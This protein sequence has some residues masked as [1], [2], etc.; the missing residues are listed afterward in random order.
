M[1]G[2]PKTLWSPLIYHIL[3]NIGSFQ[4][5]QISICY[6]R[7]LLCSLQKYG[8]TSVP[9]DSVS[10]GVP[11]TEKYDECFVFPMDPSAS[12]KEPNLDC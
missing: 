7:A 6:N 11:A 2:V 3:P 1:G 10:L 12:A 9:S 8:K 5:C 4:G